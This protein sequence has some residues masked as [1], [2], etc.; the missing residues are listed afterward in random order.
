MA[1]DGTIWDNGKNTRISD[2]YNKQLIFLYEND[3]IWSHLSKDDSYS[4]HTIYQ[5][6]SDESYKTFLDQESNTS[7]FNIDRD[8]WIIDDLMECDDTNE[9]KSSQF[10][11]LV[12]KHPLKMLQNY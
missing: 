2:Y 8:G 5:E 4:L 7:L 6:G 9:V 1:D 10:M 12:D 3:T 11:I